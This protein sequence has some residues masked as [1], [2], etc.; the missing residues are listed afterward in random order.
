MVTDF[1]YL[2]LLISNDIYNQE[3]LTFS[4][5]PIFIEKNFISTFGFQYTWLML[6]VYKVI[7][8]LI[9]LIGFKNLLDSKSRALFM[10]AA[11]LA[12]FFCIDFAPFWDRYPRPLF[13]NI[14]LISIFIA[15]LYLLQKKELRNTVFFIYGMSHA[16]L[17]LTNPWS[18]VIIAPMS[19]Y[20]IFS[21]IRLNYLL[22]PALSLFGLVLVLAPFILYFYENLD[23]SSHREYLGLKDI[24]NPVF[25]LQDYFISLLQSKQFLLV[26]LIITI[27]SLLLK[28]KFELYILILC[29]ILAPLTFVI[30]GKSVQSYHLTNGVKEFEILICVT[31]YLRLIHRSKINAFNFHIKNSDIKLFISSSFL[32]IFII[33]ILGNSWISRSLEVQENWQKYT[34]AFKSLDK[35]SK[36]CIVISNDQIIRRY[37]SGLKN[38]ETLPQDGFYR[39]SNI[40]SALK[41]VS[42][43]INILNKKKHL[44][45]EEID[46]LLKYSTHNF[47]V[48]TRST[49]T[50]TLPFKSDQEKESYIGSRRGINS[51]HHWTFAP[52]K[53]IYETLV[54]MMNHKKE[55]DV[56][57][58]TIL[59]YRTKS[60]GNVKLNILDGCTKNPNN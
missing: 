56:P 50:K 53:N 38:G 27:S 15:N 19:L 10:M 1:A 39:T 52:P 4:Y 2:K 22:K 5:L 49:I 29:T 16:V 43:A 57:K 20:S 9:F 30:L 18:A 25:Y 24:Y 47:F 33:S 3:G 55:L 34:S 6:I 41:E 13:D 14:F 11:S 48:S 51:F 23:N 44:S 26:L 54:A 36:D 42:L 40:E 60:E 32:S 59:V 12:L 17:A 46:S 7:S 35:K 21:V 8:F 45:K 37:W 28:R 31:L 58:K